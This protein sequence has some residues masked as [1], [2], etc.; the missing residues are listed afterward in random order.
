MLQLVANIYLSDI[1]SLYTHQQQQHALC[2]ILKMSVNGA[3]TVFLV[4]YLVMKAS[5]RSLHL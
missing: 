3:P 4:A 5:H 2:R 1:G